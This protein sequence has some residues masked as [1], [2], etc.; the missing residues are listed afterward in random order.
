MSLRRSR[1]LPQGNHTGRMPVPE[2]RFPLFFQE[3]PFFLFRFFAAC[4]EARTVTSAERLSSN[5]Y[6]MPRNRNF[7][8]IWRLVVASLGAAS[9]AV[10]ALVAS[11]HHGVI[12]SRGLA[13]PGATITA[14]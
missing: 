8:L 4:L 6:L 7:S 10:T 11:E 1:P 14:I 5:C 3:V 9:V 12:Q 13:V 2:G